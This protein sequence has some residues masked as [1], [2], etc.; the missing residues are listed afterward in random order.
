MLQNCFITLRQNLINTHLHH[1]FYHYSVKIEFII[2]NILPVITSRCIYC[3]VVDQ[4]KV[5]LVLQLSFHF[6]KFYR[7]SS[8]RVNN[9]PAKCLILKPRIVMLVDINMKERKVN[10]LLFSLF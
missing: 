10:G 1:D 9:F 3:S 6:G 5:Y 8:Q 4:D 7:F 2:H